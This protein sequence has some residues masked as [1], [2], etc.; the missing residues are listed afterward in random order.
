MLKE[1]WETGSNPLGLWAR[2]ENTQPR[3]MLVN[4]QYVPLYNPFAA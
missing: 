2:C 4:G 3:N 1:L